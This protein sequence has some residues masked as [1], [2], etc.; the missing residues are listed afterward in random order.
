MENKKVL[1]YI[2]I[3][4][5]LPEKSYT[6]PEG[7]GHMAESL[8]QIIHTVIPKGRVTNAFPSTL[9]YAPSIPQ[10]N[11]YVKFVSFLFIE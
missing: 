8:P 7:M 2:K 11:T 1:P 5:Y 6:F 9:V 4:I 10:H 3:F